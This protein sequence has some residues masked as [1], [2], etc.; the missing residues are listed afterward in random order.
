MLEAVSD[1]DLIQEGDTGELLAIRRCPH[2]MLSDKYLVVPYREV[3][4]E[5]G[6]ILTAYLTNEPSARRKT[7]WTR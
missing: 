3:A 1:P 7:V 6:F 4:P 2:S 5:D